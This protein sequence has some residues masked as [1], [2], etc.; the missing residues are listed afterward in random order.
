MSFNE[1]TIPKR[2]K[3]P[4][5]WASE[6]TP[7]AFIGC[8]YWKTFSFKE[9][10]QR[11]TSKWADNTVLSRYPVVR[12]GFK[13]EWAG[14]QRIFAKAVVLLYSKIVYNRAARASVLFLLNRLG[15]RLLVS[16]SHSRRDCLP[17]SHILPLY[18]SGVAYVVPVFRWE[19][20][21]QTWPTECGA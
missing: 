8:P 16:H 14:K 3:T 7:L 17:Q 21:R 10:S 13:T 5:T 4:F 15:V 18:P 2:V 19:S 11:V 6:F 12:L 1:T 20:R 9:C